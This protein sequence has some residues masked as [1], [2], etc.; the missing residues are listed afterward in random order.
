MSCRV[1][2]IALRMSLGKSCDRNNLTEVPHMRWRQWLVQ[3]VLLSSSLAHA[4]DWSAAWQAPQSDA[5]L[6]MS[7]QQATLRQIVTTHAAGSQVRI[8][9]SN[10]YGLLPVRIGAM[11]VGLSAGGA[12]VAAGGP[13]AVRF[14]GQAGIVLAPGESQYSDPVPLAV[15][16]MQRLS[17]SAFIPGAALSMSRHFTGNEFV[18]IAGGDRSGQ[19]T[20]TGF[21]QRKSALLAS[22]L[23]IDRLDV[24]DDKATSRKVVAMFGDSITDGFMGTSSG[25]PLLPSN[26]PIGRDVGFPDFLQR[27]ANAEG[28]NVTF[29]NAAI[30]GNRMLSGPFLPIFGP[31]GLSRLERDVTTLPGVTDAFILIGINDLGFSPLPGQTGQKLMAGLQDVIVKLKERGIRVTLGTLLPSKGAVYGVAHGS[32]AVNVARKALNQWVRNSSQADEVVDFDPCM[33]D[34]VK[35]DRLN[36]AF[37]SGDGLHPNTA[38]HQAMAECVDLAIFK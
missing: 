2:H 38:G 24:S 3:V 7:V 17:V 33:V 36:S 32:N 29:V 13:V 19:S 28:L 5:F 1:L 8:R 11:S 18:W 25:I 27:R 34:P 23:L 16:S 35:A 21:T 10:A 20:D 22:T 31:S 6:S 9:V 15:T 4:S 26:E 30:S 37:D 12:Q 14:N